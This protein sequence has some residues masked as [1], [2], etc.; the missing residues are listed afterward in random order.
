MT[1]DRPVVQAEREARAGKYRMR[2][3]VPFYRLSGLVWRLARW[4]EAPAICPDCTG[5][6]IGGECPACRERDDEQRMLNEAYVDGGA[7]AWRDA[8]HEMGGCRA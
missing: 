7:D 5:D 4:V 3:C 8:Q 6:M 1:P 2:L